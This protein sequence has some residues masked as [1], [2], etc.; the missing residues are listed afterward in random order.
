MSTP[1][2]EL[3]T[4]LVDWL[5][6]V[7]ARTSLSR[8]ARLM[9][10]DKKL[11]TKHITV[12]FNDLV[13]SGEINVLYKMPKSALLSDVGITEEDFQLAKEYLAT[14]PESEKFQIVVSS[15]DYRGNREEA[16]EIRQKLR[17]DNK[18]IIGFVVERFENMAMQLL[19]NIP[20]ETKSEVRKAIKQGNFGSFEF[21]DFGDGDP[22]KT[23]VIND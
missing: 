21:S 8:L 18:A 10:E 1:N 15:I 3:A 16:I 20:E 5:E 22:D 23:S 4:E 19:G 2:E 7:G 12:D 13:K 14:I 17:N 11:T 9:A 6:Q